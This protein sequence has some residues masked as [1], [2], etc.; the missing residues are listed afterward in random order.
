MQLRTLITGS[1]GFPF[2]STRRQD[3]LLLGDMEIIMNH[4]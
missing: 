3:D 2:N 4:H 1:P